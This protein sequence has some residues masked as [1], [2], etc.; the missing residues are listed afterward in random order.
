MVDFVHLAVDFDRT[1]LESLSTDRREALVLSSRKLAD[2]LRRRDIPTI[3]VSFPR[4][5][6]AFALHEAPVEWPARNP[7]QSPKNRLV[8]AG[9]GNGIDVKT[10][11][12]IFMKGKEDAFGDGSLAKIIR[13]KYGASGILVSGGTVTICVP[14]TMT[15]GLRNGFSVGALHDHCYS[16]LDWDKDPAAHKNFLQNWGKQHGLS[17][18][19]YRVV[20]AEQLLAEHP[21]RQAVPHALPAYALRR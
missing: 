9:F 6:T 4:A 15:G 18:D 2:E 11:E 12:D 3:W 20:S 7:R 5:N 8:P 13:H 14:G 16:T 21:Q 19:A 10:D 1:N 17:A